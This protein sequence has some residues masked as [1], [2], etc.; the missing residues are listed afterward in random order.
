M[1]Q[2]T[3][4]RR[5]R[6]TVADVPDHAGVPGAHS[7]RQRRQGRNP[8]SSAAAAVEKNRMFSLFGALAG[9]IGRQ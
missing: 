8:A 9:Q 1:T 2:V 4:R 3:N 6:R 5:P 7:G